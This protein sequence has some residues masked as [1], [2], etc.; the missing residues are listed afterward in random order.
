MRVFLPLAVL[1]IPV[2][3]DTVTILLGTIRSRITKIM[4]SSGRDIKVSY[5]IE[6]IHYGLV[7]ENF[8]LERAHSNAHRV[9]RR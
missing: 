7:S 3:V 5:Y 8:V 1:V 2:Y 9:C 6:T 4:S